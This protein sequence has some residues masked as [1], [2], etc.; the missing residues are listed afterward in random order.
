M[1]LKENLTELPLF[2]AISSKCICWHGHSLHHGFI[3]TD[4][5]QQGI[6]FFETHTS[7]FRS[8]TQRCGSKM[9]EGTRRARTERKVV[10]IGTWPNDVREYIASSTVPDDNPGYNVVNRTH[11]ATHPLRVHDSLAPKLSVHLR[12]RVYIAR[13]PKPL[14]PAT[15]LGEGV[16]ALQE[17]THLIYLATDLGG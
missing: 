5:C 2:L 14:N 12:P 10:S 11:C 15:N 1:E 16:I 17:Y 4:K 13:S 7:R 6:D 8:C 3:W 9:A